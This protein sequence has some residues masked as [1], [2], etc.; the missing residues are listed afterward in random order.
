MTRKCSSLR[1]DQIEMSL[2]TYLGSENGI[3]PPGGERITLIMIG[4]QVTS[5]KAGSDIYLR[6]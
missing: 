4:A 5:L 1:L 3:F 2:A 6:D